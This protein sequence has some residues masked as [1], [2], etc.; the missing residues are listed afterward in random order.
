V[1]FGWIGVTPDVSNVIRK[2]ESGL[3]SVWIAKCA[4]VKPW[5]PAVTSKQKP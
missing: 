3:Q 4:F 1:R 5:P 2:V